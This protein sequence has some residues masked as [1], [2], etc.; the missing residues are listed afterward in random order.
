[1]SESNLVYSCPA[2]LEIPPDG[3]AVKVVKALAMLRVL[4]FARLW[5][6]LPRLQNIFYAQEYMYARVLNLALLM[7]IVS[8]WNGCLHFLVDYYLDFPPK[9]WVALNN[10]QVSE[11][12]RGQENERSSTRLA[13]T[14]TNIQ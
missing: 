4:R 11:I 5:R 7:V 3:S 8:H 9:C 13:Q 6:Y 10:L 1:M 2:D 12:H 14:A